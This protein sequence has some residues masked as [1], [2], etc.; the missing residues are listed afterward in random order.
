[1]GTTKEDSASIEGTAAVSPD[2]LEPSASEPRAGVPV[3]GVESLVGP[4]ASSQGAAA[5]VG[6]ERFELLR[7]VGAGG[8]GA[9]YEAIDRERGQRVALKTLRNFGPLELFLFK[10]EF[11]SLSD[12][13]HPNL[14]GL[15]ELLAEGSTWFFTMDYVPGV[16]FLGWVRGDVPP[17]SPG[18]LDPS[19]EPA[20]ASPAASASPGPD[21]GPRTDASTFPDAVALAAA[22]QARP[23]GAPPPPDTMA[24]EL[25][26]DR[27]PSGAPLVPETVALELN[28]DGSPSGAPLMPE[29]VALELDADGSPSGAPLVP[30]TMALELPVSGPPSD[31]VSGPLSAALSKLDASASSS[32][33]PPEPQHPP[34]DEDGLVRLRSVLVQLCTAVRA[35]HGFGK[36]HRDI[37]PSNILVDA[38]GRVVLLDFGLIV[39]LREDGEGPAAG[40]IA[41]TARY[42]SPEQARGEA[43]SAASDWYA[44]GCLLHEALL[45]KPLFEGNTLEVVLSKAR[46]R[47]LPPLP[48]PVA[49]LAPDLAALCA[50]LLRQDPSERPDGADVLARLGVEGKDTARDTLSSAPVSAGGGRGSLIGR[51]E[52]LAALRGA[53]AAAQRG[54]TEVVFVHGRSG[55]GKSE[56]ISRFLSEL[57]D[58]GALV[59]TSRCYER[60]WV[61]FKAVDPL[62]DALVEALLQR[63]S[64]APVPI[65]VG[66]LVRLFPVLRRVPSLAAA[67]AGEA[68]VTEP[69]ELRRRAVAGFADLLRKVALDTPVALFIDDLQWSDFDS[70]YVFEELLGEPSPPPLLLLGA[71]RDEEADTSLLL[72][73]FGEL[74]VGANQAPVTRLGVGPLSE[75]D[76]RILAAEHVGGTDE[77]LVDAVASESRGVPFFIDELARYVRSVPEGS[78]RGVLN[79]DEVVRSR[80]AALPT[81][82]R[83]LLEVAATAGQP[84]SLPLLASVRE[85]AEAWKVAIVLQGEHLLHKLGSGDARDD[86][87]ECYHD[88]IREAVFA[89]LST[90]AACGLHL[91]LAD[92]FEAQPSPDAERLAVHLLAAGERARALPWVRSAAESADRALAFERAAGLYGRAVELEEDATEQRRLRTAQAQALVNA[93]RGVEAATAYLAAAEGASTEDAWRFTQAAADQLL[94]AGRLEEGNELVQQVLV[95]A[96]MSLPSNELGV[97]LRYLG[98][99]IR[100]SFRG[101]DFVE[102]PASELSTE[103]LGRLDVALSASTVLAMTD[104]LAG[105]LMHTRNLQ[106][107][108]DAGEPYRVVRALGV[109]ASFASV[110]GMKGEAKANGILDTAWELS[111]RLDDPR[112]LGFSMMTRSLVRFQAGRWKESAQAANEAS[113]VLLENC[114]GMHYEVGLARAYELAD[115]AWLGRLR[116]FAHCSEDWIDEATDRGDLNAWLLLR[117]GGPV[118]VGALKDQ[119]EAAAEEVL[120]VRSRW[121]DARFG[122]LDVYVQRSLLDLALYRADAGAALEHAEALWAGLFKSQLKVVALLQAT[123]FDGMARALLA[124]GGDPKR[125]ARCVKKLGVHGPGWGHA[126]A[127]LLA[128]RSAGVEGWRAAVSTCEAADMAMHAAAARWR[129]GEA[130]GGDEGEA[131]VAGARTW[132]TD[133]GVARPERLVA[134][135]TP[136]T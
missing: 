71:W 68:L 19:A 44:V 37:K 133:E 38:D 47:V 82:A 78:W 31:A 84:T 58:A 116:A 30:D 26:A 115:L 104:T 64:E 25:N 79:L 93:G 54:G 118:Q 125:L 52:H 112:A 80:V 109:E 113:A 35:L 5:F 28:A 48:E 4:G 56:L 131:M 95:E 86:R 51:D 134:M 123:A 117:L 114:H 13:V 122:I 45:G 136:G 120:D 81:V 88:R 7:H 135:L 91:S 97:I 17:A 98:N 27:S 105:A 110:V 130:V 69:T 76:A 70:V 32:P 3:A 101:L 60:E 41:G 29:T 1:M 49:A 61:P 20:P 59:L 9:V 128:A 67:S 15:H 21:G 63:G 89:S 96:G 46:G 12:I 119:P 22:R 107:A 106:M 102:R 8:M 111:Q 121:P 77:E 108:L 36:L 100:L 66:S 126:P 50:D 103:E 42:M 14:V 129:L 53:S 2:L 94:R 33:S 16:D 18:E 92:R 85:V 127:S 11:R 87:V 124:T 75:A 90:D 23:S 73:A 43:L 34:L 65:N 72:K 10:N 99:R 74:V 57:R 55:M 39:D 62:I 40:M 6:S 24:L 132:F 83:E